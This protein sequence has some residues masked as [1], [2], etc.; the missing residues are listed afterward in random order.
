LPNHRESKLKI[1]VILFDFGDTLVSFED[2]DYEASLR[3]LYRKLVEN[4][5]KV[6]YE[7]FR[8]TYFKVREQLYKE[9]NASLKEVN[10][11]VRVASV[12][13]E[14]GFKLSPK[15][16]KVI[17]SVEAFMESL[18]ESLKLDLQTPEILRRLKEKYKLGLVSN[19]AYPPTIKQVLAKFGLLKF[20]DVV[21][22]SG[23]IGWRKPSPKIFEAALKE[24]KVNALETV[25]VGDA[26]FHDIA[27]AGRLGMKTILLTPSDKGKQQIW[28]SL[29]R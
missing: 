24:L 29:T 10:F 6:S 25:F 28:E 1:K 2:F 20:F 7:K 16:P 4:D 14:L 15:D 3:A 17:S 23:D 27:G 22:V 12:L 5:I 21:V 19:F 9:T 26:P 18:K 13:S 11:C 8:A